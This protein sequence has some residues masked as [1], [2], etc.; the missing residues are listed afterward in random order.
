MNLKMWVSIREP[1][2]LIVHKPKR[3]RKNGKISKKC[4]KFNQNDA[5]TTF[6]NKNDFYNLKNLRN[7]YKIISKE[8]SYRLEKLEYL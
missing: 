4:H 8:M 6:I 7:N 3:F 1:T 2:V 5:I